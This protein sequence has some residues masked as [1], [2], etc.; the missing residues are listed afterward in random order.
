MTR[1]DVM[2]LVSLRSLAK[3]NIYTKQIF[4]KLFIDELNRRLP[5]Y[6]Y[7]IDRD[8]QYISLVLNNTE[9][10]YTRNNVLRTI[11]ESFNESMVMYI[12]TNK[13]DNIDEY[14]PLSTLSILD[15]GR[16]IDICVLLNGVINIYL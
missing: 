9:N 11:A 5:I 3:K 6:S 15:A 16:I 12:G 8:N 2:D 10:S 14:R 13:D 7:N 1:T 4:Y